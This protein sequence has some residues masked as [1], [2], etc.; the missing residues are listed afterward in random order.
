MQG[1]GTILI[2]D[3]D[4]PTRAFIA[5]AL[6][7]EG[8]ITWTAHDAT[9][10]LAAI[11]QH[12]PNLVLFDLPLLGSTTTCPLAA[13]RSNHAG[14]RLVVMTT[15]RTAAETL[16]VQDITDC[17][18]KPFSLDELLDCVARYIP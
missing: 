12:P 5:E 7:D 10:A 4:A 2:V 13:L 3:D 9:T 16:L 1:V 6:G 14:L 11:S 15:N 8:Y 17:L 18:V